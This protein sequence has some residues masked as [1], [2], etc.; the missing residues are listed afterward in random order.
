MPMRR[1]V[2]AVEPEDAD[3]EFAE[4]RCSLVMPLLVAS[5]VPQA[6]YCERSIAERQTSQ[7]RLRPTVRRQLANP[8]AFGRG[9]T[10]SIKL[11]CAALVVL[12]APIRERMARAARQVGRDR[13]RVMSSL[14]V[15]AS[16]SPRRI[17]ML[18]K[19]AVPHA[20]YPVEI[21]ETPRPGESAEALVLRLSQEKADA[22][23]LRVSRDTGAADATPI[24]AADTVVVAMSDGQPSLL[25]KPPHAG[26]ARQMLA[27]LSGVTHRVVT[28]YHLRL[29]AASDG[30]VTRLH[31][32]VSTD[33]EVRPLLPI[34]VEGYLRSE[35]WRGKAGGY[36]LQGLFSC[37]VRAIH[38]SYENVVGLPLS[39]VLDDLRATGLLPADWPDW[40]P[41]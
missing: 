7:F 3:G 40:R 10:Q 5:H 8:H 13:L 27:L 18:Q 33:V 1:L 35:E 11:R 6:R 22:A 23:A 20:V 32:A 19:A 36:A 41:Q 2:A 4:E 9:R 17:A 25:G 21:D 15:L 26:A 16:A 30:S 38:G 24:L 12:A 31:R 28:G 14:L 34:E 29:P 37:F 39:A